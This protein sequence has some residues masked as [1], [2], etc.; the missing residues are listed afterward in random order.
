[1]YY[2]ILLEAETPLSLRS[3]RNTTQSDTLDYIPG[4][5]I[6]GTLA[7]AHQLLERDENKFTTFFL[8]ESIRFG[9]HYPSSFCAK[10]LYGQYDPV[11]PMPLT[12]RSCKRFSGFRFHA[13]KEEKQ[14]QGVTDMLIPL[15][16]FALSSETC[17]DVLK[18]WDKCNCNVPDDQKHPLDRV[19]GFFRRGVQPKHYGQPKPKKAL[20][21]RTGI[22]YDTGIVQSSILYSRQVIEKGSTFWGMCFVDDEL[23]EAFD[24]FVKETQECGLLRVGNNRTRGFGRISFNH[25]SMECDSAT[26]IQNRVEAFTKQFKQAAEAAKIDAPAHLY[27]PI[28]LT[29]DAILPDP[30]LRAR[31]RLMADDLATAGIANAELVFHVAGT[32]QI[33]GWSNLW[34]LPKAD[35]WAIAMGSVFLFALPDTTEDTFTALLR[36]QQEGIGLRRAEGFGMIHI[37]H[38]FHVELAG[39]YR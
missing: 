3:G 29:S 7:Q 39:V 11:L 27:V 28:L 4:G 1:M 32:R 2:R 10:E 25:S 23:V 13:D 34:G 38:P 8:R 21:T 19:K 26:D 35:D 36:L 14:R 6:L 16:L 37:A 17:I 22:N 18:P 15:A 30:L 12:A 5:S 20:R 31:M 33:Q 9:N 24:A